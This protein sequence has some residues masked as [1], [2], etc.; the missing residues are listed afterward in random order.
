M[1]LARMFDTWTPAVL[2]EMYRCSPI[3]RLLRP[4]VKSSSISSSRLV[5]P[6]GFSCWAG[7]AVVLTGIRDRLASF[8]IWVR[9]GPA[10]RSVA[11]DAASVRRTVACFLSWADSAARGGAEEGLCQR[12]G[13][14]QA[15]SRG[16]WNPGEALIPEPGAQPY[17]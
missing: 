7:G 4:A 12:V 5:R 3:W 13:L 2:V 15:A 6:A 10:P 11:I 17:E 14:L 16:C 8:S 9:S 1:S